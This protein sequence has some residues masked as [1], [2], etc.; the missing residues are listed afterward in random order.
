MRCSPR[1]RRTARTVGRKLCNAWGLFDMHGNVW[2]WCQDWEGSDRVF[3]GGS[4][5]TP[6]AGCRSAYRS[7]GEQNDRNYFVGFR[8]AAVPSTGEADTAGSDSP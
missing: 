6:A 7:S 3:R 4:W 1:T 8:V 5:M 2:E